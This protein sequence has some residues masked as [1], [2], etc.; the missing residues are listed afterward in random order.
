MKFDF[1]FLDITHYIQNE[2]IYLMEVLQFLN[3]RALV[4]LH[5]I[6][7]LLNATENFKEVKFTLTLIYLISSLYGQKI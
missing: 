6:K 2:I 1:L 4:V 7:W 5:V 3:E